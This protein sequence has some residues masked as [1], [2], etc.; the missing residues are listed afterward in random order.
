MKW[1]AS[2]RWAVSHIP[3]TVL[4][5]SALERDFSLWEA[6]DL[7]EVGER[8]ITLRYATAF[9]EVCKHPLMRLFDEVVDKK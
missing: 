6:G 9:Y 7:T 3:S 2:G 4:A 8:G 5:Q 1:L